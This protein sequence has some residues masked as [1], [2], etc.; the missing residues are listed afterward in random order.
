MIVLIIIG[1]IFIVLGV[2]ILIGKGDFLI[3]GYNNARKEEKDKINVKR[4][5]YVIA[6]LLFIIP[7]ILSIPILI[8]QEENA[9]AHFLTVIYAFI[10]IIVA[11]ILANTWCIKK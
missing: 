8:G 3:A 7:A 9:V 6:G 11:I 10:M 4:L 2:I 1:I 5:R